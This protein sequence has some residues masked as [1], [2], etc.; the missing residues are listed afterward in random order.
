MHDACIFQI[1]NTMLL[2]YLDSNYCT[3]LLKNCTYNLFCHQLMNKEKMRIY[4]YLFKNGCICVCIYIYIYIYVCVCVCVFTVH[5]AAVHLMINFS[6]GL[7]Y[8]DE[9]IC[10]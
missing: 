8:C 7:H 2:F 1:K 9:G 6:F 3:L 10:Q 4:L 5:V